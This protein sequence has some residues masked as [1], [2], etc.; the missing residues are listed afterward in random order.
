MTRIIGGYETVT[1]DRDGVT[2]VPSGKKWRVKNAR[3]NFSDGEWTLE[4]PDDYDRFDNPCEIRSPQN[5]R[6]RNTS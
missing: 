2:H 4:M 1:L 6:E 5:S 3:Y